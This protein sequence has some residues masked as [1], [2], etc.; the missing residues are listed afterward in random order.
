[1]SFSLLLLYILRNNC[2]GKQASILTPLFSLLIQSRR[3]G[4]K[5]LICEEGTALVWLRSFFHIYETQPYVF[6]TFSSLLYPFHTFENVCWRDVN[7]HFSLQSFSPQIMNHFDIC[8]QF[9]FCLKQST[10]CGNFTEIFYHTTCLVGECLCGCWC[11]WG[12]CMNVC[13]LMQIKINLQ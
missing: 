1:M 13:V 7:W 2:L 11:V 5:C 4:T 10:G 9:Q 3:A 12:F 8:S 6:T